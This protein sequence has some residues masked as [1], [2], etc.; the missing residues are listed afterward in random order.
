MVMREREKQIIAL[1][2][3]VAL[4]CRILGKLGLA[5]WLGHVSA[6]VPGDNCMVIKGLGIDLGDLQKTTFDKIITVSLDGE[7]VEGQHRFPGETPLH[8]EIYKYRP[9]VGGIVHT[10][11]RTTLAFGTTGRKILPLQ[12]IMAWMVAQDLPRYPSSLMVS[13]VEQA[14]E[15]AHLLGG[16]QACHL[17]NHGVVVVGKTIEEAV[18]SCIDLEDLA[19]L[20]MM[21]ESLGKPYVMSEQ[22]IRLKKERSEIYIEACWRYYSELVA[23]GG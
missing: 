21:A 12:G 11:Q 23:G 22:E 9:D 4:G 16:H 19:K 3:K 14:R 17:V 10:H 8:T 6:R 7:L 13:T 18:I 5:D 2:E 20:T 1:K 15:V